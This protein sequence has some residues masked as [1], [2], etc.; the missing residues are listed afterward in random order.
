MQDDGSK[1]ATLNNKSVDFKA[2]ELS[3]REK[4]EKAKAEKEARAK[5]EAT[6]R[7]NPTTTESPQP[8]V[9][10]QTTGPPP[11]P[12]LNNTT[13]PTPIPVTSYPQQT[14]PANLGYTQHPHMT[15][16]SRQP[17]QYTVPYPYGTQPYTNG[18]PQ[19][20][21]QWGYGT[22]LQTTPG[23][24]A[25]PSQPNQG[26]TVHGPPNQ[27][28]PGQIPSSASPPNNIRVPA[29]QS[30]NDPPGFALS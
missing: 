23:V 19:P 8:V 17:F 7:T 13:I 20:Y 11:P 28:S 5:A 4:L 16:Y 14:W 25:P 10:E 3:L 30:S 18:Q 24:P 26:P 21:A 1:Q 6:L 9:S 27:I 12:G 22:P 15:A 2:H 29:N